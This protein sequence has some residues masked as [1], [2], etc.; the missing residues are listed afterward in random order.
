MNIIDLKK[1]KIDSPTPQ[2]IAKEELYNSTFYEYVMNVP[3]KVDPII[4]QMILTLITPAL[5]QKFFEQAPKRSQVLIDN[6][7]EIKPED[8]EF[9]SNM[10]DIASSINYIFKHYFYSFQEDLSKT[11][12]EEALD[13]NQ[14]FYFECESLYRDLP[15]SFVFAIVDLV[16]QI[17]GLK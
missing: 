14:D 13:K 6:Y 12:Y 17:K 5:S 1:R 10:P 15:A 3:K 16:E 11:S 9:I 2:D 7:L 8:K 4:H